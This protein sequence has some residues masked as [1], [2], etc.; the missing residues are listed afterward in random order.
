MCSSLKP[1]D[2][3]AVTEH[4][5]VFQPFCS[6]WVTYRCAH[7]P[8]SCLIHL[9]ITF[10]NHGEWGAAF[11]LPCQALNNLLWA[12]F[13]L[14]WIVLG[15]SFPTTE[16]HKIKDSSFEQCNC[17]FCI[18]VCIDLLFL[19]RLTFLGSSP[20]SLYMDRPSY[21][22][23]DHGGGRW[24]L[25]LTQLASTS[26]CLW[27]VCN[28]FMMSSWIMAVLNNRSLGSFSSNSNT[29]MFPASYTKT[30]DAY[31]IHIIL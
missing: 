10:L 7:T 31:I 4:E 16:P 15:E 9:D 23:K 28:E 12:H 1:T 30:I 8:V 18:S 6:C 27:E 5:I 20:V 22:P 24:M 29:G 3:H 17:L 19:V 2:S 25:T 21:L 11:K 14:S 26:L 13:L